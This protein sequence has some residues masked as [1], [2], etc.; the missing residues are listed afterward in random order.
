MSEADRAARRLAAIVESSNEAI[1]SMSYPGRIVDSWNAAAERLF[2]Y[3]AEEMIGRHIGAVVPAELEAE[4]LELLAG[5]ARGT[6]V[7]DFETVRLHRDGHRIEVSLSISPMTGSDGAVNG[8][9]VLLRDLTERRRLERERE[10]LLENERRARAEAET[11]RERTARLGAVSAALSTALT[12]AQVARVVVD[13]G[14]TL[15]GARAGFLGLADEDGETLHML[16]VHGFPPGLRER[17]AALPI[18]MP[19]SALARTARTGQPAYFRSG[20]E[21]ARRFPSR[22]GDLEAVG[23]GAVAMLPLP[24]ASA[25]RGVLA[26]T[27]AGDRDFGARERALL[28]TLAEQCTVALERALLHER[29]HE[30]AATLQRSLLPRALPAIPGVE[31]AASYR[32]ASVVAEVGGD[33]YDV[34]DGGDGSWTLLVGDVCGKGIDAAASTGMIRHTARAAVYRGAG[35]ADVLGEVNGAMLRAGG[36][37][38]R[39]FATLAAARLWPGRAGARA[40]VASAGHPPP[41]ALR[42][43]RVRAVGGLGPLAG[44]YADAAYPVQTVE[45]AAGEPLILYTDGI[46]EARA[47]GAVYG[48]DRLA[49][50]IGRLDGR[51]ADALVAAVVDAVTAYA[52]A[53]GDDMAIVCV[54]PAPAG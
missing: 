23:G 7:A 13:G 15:L 3:R 43:G 42:G 36:D 24:G 44:V 25:V 17:Y 51:P 10:E 22:A 4:T 14:S 49:A 8:L 33:L 50:L 47:D 12:P 27:F 6:P 48:A 35:P 30:I 39:D 21:Y 38:A 16:G 9:S 18:A 2:G 26:W 54:R 29:D 45:L 31:L 52:G 11:E 46:T 5:V 32:P 40:D 34:V 28:R 41:L 53:P 19:D 20:E 1:L 37:P